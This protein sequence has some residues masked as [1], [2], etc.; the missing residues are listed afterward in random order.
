MQSASRVGLPRA[1]SFAAVSLGFIVSTLS[2][3]GSASEAPA[4]SSLT[5][6]ALDASS[7]DAPAL[8]AS[9]VDAP[10]LDASVVDA[11]TAPD[12]P[13]DTPQTDSAAFPCGLNFT[14]PSGY[15]CVGLSTTSCVRAAAVGEPCR[16]GPAD[17]IYCIPGATCE[18]VRGE[19]LRRVWDG[20][21][22]CRNTDGCSPKCDPGL[23][24]DPGTHCRPGLALGELCGGAGDFCNDGS[25]CQDVNGTSRCIADGAA[26]GYCRVGRLCDAGLLCQGSNSGSASG[27]NREYFRCSPGLLLGEV[28][29]PTGVPCGAGTT[30]Q[31]SY[32]AM[33]CVAH[34]DGTP[35]GRCR[36]ESP[37]CDAEAVC[38]DRG[39][40]CLRRVP[41][42][43]PCD[44][45]GGTTACAE[46]DTC[47]AEHL[48][49]GGRCVAAGTAPGAD[50]RA[51]EPP[52]DGELQCSTF[53]RYRRTCRTLAR[54]GDRCDLGGVRTVCPSPTRCV[55]ATAFSLGAAIST[56]TAPIPETEPNDRSVRTR[57]L[58]ERSV[59][60][61]SSLSTDDPEDCHA[62]RMPAGS[63]LYVET[64]VSLVARLF[65]S[66]GVEIG[67]WTLR[68]AS[69][70]G[71]LAASA[72]LD[73]AA[74]GVLRD[75][76]ADDYL[77]CL[78]ERGDSMPRPSSV[79]YTLAIGVLPAMI[80][81]PPP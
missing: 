40:R 7:V 34:P 78:R 9:S 45:T 47:D 24:C 31:M 46:G 51:S 29:E 16:N 80:A 13:V 62:V 48:A 67:R 33:R 8:D 38:D 15:R 63:S 57:A 58:V 26:G 42:G 19:P 36:A 14:C 75:L 3:C 41:R 35:G 30:C 11:S 17:A 22:V 21:R 37:R 55:P 68:S 54:A 60:F 28:C 6:P 74:I 66:S 69:P 70:G 79:D 10:A 20:L 18:P 25:S 77:L 56:C 52:C 39:W 53:S 1:R 4:D 32:G 81:S 71:P 76:A 73:P 27:C 12:V 65:R 61:Q 72:R 23:G 49:D 50:C 5:A 43:M 59:L 2:A 44:P 64:S